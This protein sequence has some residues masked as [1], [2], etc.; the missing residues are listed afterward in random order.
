MVRILTG[1]AQGPIS[2]LFTEAPVSGFKGGHYIGWGDGRFL[3]F[4]ASGVESMN[5][6]HKSVV[7]VK[8]LV[9]NHGGT[10]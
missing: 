9:R 3:D 5:M 2:L 7:N 6:T 8:I 10:Y 4:P 1:E